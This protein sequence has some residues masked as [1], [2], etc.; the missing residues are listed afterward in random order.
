MYQHF[1]EIPSHEHILQENSWSWSF[2]AVRV[3]EDWHSFFWSILQTI[4]TTVCGS[5]CTYIF[6]PLTTIL[7]SIL[8]AFQPPRFNSQNA[9]IFIPGTTIFRRILQAFQRTSCRSLCTRINKHELTRAR[10]LQWTPIHKS[11]FETIHLTICS[12]N[13]TCP[14][15]PWTP[16]LMSIF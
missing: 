14:C 1:L 12:S 5:K 16:I 3:R 15:I 7:L 9:C 13:F 10:S 4:Q 6:F 8:Y 2:V 11:I